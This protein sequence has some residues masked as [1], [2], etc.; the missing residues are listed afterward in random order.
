MAN[1]ALG[2]LFYFMPVY[3]SLSFFIISDVYPSPDITSSAVLSMMSLGIP[4]AS[5]EEVAVCDEKLR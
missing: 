4:A 2:I 1:N 5:A 3:L